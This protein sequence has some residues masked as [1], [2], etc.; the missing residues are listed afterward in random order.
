MFNVCWRKRSLHPSRFTFICSESPIG[1]ALYPLD[2]FI[3][4]A[5]SVGG[6]GSQR[7]HVRA[8]Y[9][10]HNPKIVHPRICLTMHQFSQV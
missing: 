2:Y 10:E 4:Q 9:S 1:L 8:R 6:G 5:S 7:A 3:L